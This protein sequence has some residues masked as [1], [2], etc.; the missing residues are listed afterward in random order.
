MYLIYSIL[1][2]ETEC[3]FTRW[4][5]SYLFNIFKKLKFM[6]SCFR[7][8]DLK[9]VGEWK[10]AHLKVVRWVITH[11]NYHNAKGLMQFKKGVCSFN[12]LTTSKA[13]T[14][15]LCVLPICCHLLSFILFC[16]TLTNPG[17]EMRIVVRRTTRSTFQVVRKILGHKFWDIKK[18]KKANTT[19]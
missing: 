12:K 6:N 4:C 14:L 3:T 10:K 2:F 11:H 9:I 13:R 18:W 19:S 7:P 17:H 15:S 16:V 8:S 5:T 1:L